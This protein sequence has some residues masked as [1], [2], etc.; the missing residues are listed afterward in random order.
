[1][2]V[3]SGCTGMEP[4]NESDRLRQ[5]A[6]QCH[7]SIGPHRIVGMSEWNRRAGQKRHRIESIGTE[8]I[9]SQPRTLR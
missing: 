4:K 5:D 8:S 7:A 2:S 9:V 3:G 1:M 6:Q